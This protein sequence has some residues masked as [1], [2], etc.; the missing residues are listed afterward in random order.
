MIS[1]VVDPSV[2]V[3]AF[4][5]RE[6]AAP[7]QIT[8]ALKARRFT[9]VTS[10]LLIA[11]LRDVLG[12]P[13]FARWTSDD[14]GAD[15]VSG[16]EARGDQHSDP[17]DIPRVVRDPNDDYLVALTRASSATALVSVDLD[18]LEANLDEVT[19]YTPRAFV[20]ML[21]AAS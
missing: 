16:L 4:I 6:D 14:R 5:G 20:E 9:L 3:S 8:S 18:L 11:E 12:R 13:K 21:V 19:V 17:P 10:P 1:A 15:F 2:L 7:G